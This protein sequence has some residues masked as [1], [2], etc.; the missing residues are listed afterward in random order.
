V[1]VTREI[2][3]P[4]PPEEVWAALTEA[5]RL[6]E[7]FANRVELEVEEG[8][9]GVF[10]W[11]D[12]EVRVA[13]VEEVVPVRRLA[14]RWSDGETGESR[15]VFTLA[16]A[17]EGTRLTVTETQIGPTACAGWATAVALRTVLAAVGA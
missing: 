11:G 10:R 14:F 5:E 15:V 13:L 4:E 16:G 8:G 3:L 9:S 12:G 2:V 7:W 6:E 17:D 1:E